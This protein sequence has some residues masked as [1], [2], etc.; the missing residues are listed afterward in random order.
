[1]GQ[2]DVTPQADLASQDIQDIHFPGVRFDTGKNAIGNV[3][4]V[5]DGGQVFID[6]GFNDGLIESQ[7]LPVSRENSSL[8]TVEVVEVF[9]DRSRCLS[10]KPLELGDSVQ[11]SSAI[12]LSGRCEDE[13]GVVLAGVAVGLLRSSF[14]NIDA[15]ALIF[16]TLSDADGRFEFPKVDAIRYATNRLDLLLVAKKAGYA[17]QAERIAVDQLETQLQLD[18]RTGALVGIVLGPN[19]ERVVNATVHATALPIGL[20]NVGTTT[21]DEN[22]KF[23]LSDLHQVDDQPFPI[24]IDHPDYGAH[25]LFVPKVPGVFNAKL[26]SPAII[27]GSVIDKFTGRPIPG[28]AVS[29]QGIGT[30]AWY[31]TRTGENG[32]YQLAI[33][34]PDRYNIWGEFDGRVPIAIDALD[35]QLGKTQSEID[36]HMV[37]GAVIVGKLLDGQGMPLKFSIRQRVAHHGPARPRNGAAVTSTSI[38]SDGS[39]RLRVAPGKN[40]I[41]LMQGSASV[42]VEVEDQQELHVELLL[43]KSEP[44]PERSIKPM[45]RPAPAL[46]ARNNFKASRNRFN[47]PVGRLLDDLEFM[48][49][50]A[51][52]FSDEWL[53]GLKNLADFGA[54][55]IPELC[56]ELDATDDD[57]M[58]RS[59]GFILRAIDDP[60]AVPALIRAIPRTLRKPGS[61]MG[62]SVNDKQ[63]EEFAHKFDLHEEDTPGEYGFGRPVREILT[64]LQELTDNDLDDDQLFGIFK[65]GTAQQQA[66]KLKLFERHSLKWETWWRDNGGKFEV[67][68]AYRDVDLPAYEEV[69]TVPAVQLEKHYRVD[70][71]GS[72]WILQSASE[73]NARTVFLDFDT[74][75]TS[76]LPQRWR[77]QDDL[78]MDEIERWAENEGFDMMGLRIPTGYADEQVYVLQNLGMKVW[79]LDDKRW[80]TRPEKITIAEL[81]DEGR[82]V[83]KYLI[84]ET[85]NARDPFATASFLVITREGTP[86]M[87]HV[88]IEVL[89]DSLKPGGVVGDDTELDPVAFHKGRRFAFS[90]FEDSSP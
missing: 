62:L 55:A 43:G 71:G 45:R 6:L 40:Y 41:Y 74:G 46:A 58:L 27:Q 56:D 26:F 52:R 30:H 49:S 44:P 20:P 14:K 68:A 2:V 77:N 29:A 85:A 25:R 89:D 18:S 47:T 76:N 17:T 67:P 12:S 28:C 5:G 21:T 15:P 54:E 39:F 70:G 8:G 33:T 37:H 78:P 10:D 66:M 32:K 88:G 60:R 90:F 48:N 36:I 22:G 23:L 35:V 59:L 84:R 75:R 34:E 83:D 11:S 73:P 1:M 4:E 19:G 50:G 69:V 13:R 79:Q 64:T 9:A 51:T 87:V 81:I 63:L 31:Q 38:A 80:K 16:S 86:V 3:I 53:R 72:N 7:L 82:E 65:Q 57:M 24:T 61:D 42:N